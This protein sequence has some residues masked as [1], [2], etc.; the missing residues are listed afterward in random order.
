MPWPLWNTSSAPLAIR[1]LAARS[2][3]QL[4]GRG[5]TQSTASE[6]LGTHQ[7]SGLVKAVQEP[8]CGSGRDPGGISILCG[9]PGSARRH[10]PQAE[11]KCLVQERTVAS[12]AGRSFPSLSVRLQPSSCGKTVLCTPLLGGCSQHPCCHCSV[13]S[14][15]LPVSWYLLSPPYRKQESK[16]HLDESVFGRI[17]HHQGR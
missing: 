12:S 14:L 7:G 16:G 3:P 5:T 9:S 1:Q 15:L 2:L 17:V 6:R 8:V 11:P 4:C 10:R 13:L